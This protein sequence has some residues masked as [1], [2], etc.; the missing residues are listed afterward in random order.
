M[1]KSILL[2]LFTSLILVPVVASNYVFAKELPVIDFFY[3]ETCPHCI[4]EQAFFDEL[5]ELYPDLEVNRYSVS[6]EAN[7]DPMRERL[8]EVDAEKYF[9]SV[10]LTFVGDEF[11]LGFDDENGIGRDIVE[12]IDRQLSGEETRE[13]G[14]GLSVPFIGEVDVSQYSLPS[15]AVVLG[16]LDGFNVCSL[17]A[18]VL[19]LGMALM[20]QSRKKIALYGGIFIFTTAII[21]GSLIFLW[22]SLFSA[23]AKY[24]GL[25]QISIGLLGFVGG[26]YFLREYVKMRKYG[27]TCNSNG[28]PIIGKLSERMQKVFEGGSSAVS[29]GLAILL[30][31]AA[32]TIVEFPCS[33]AV[34]VFFAGVLADASLV[35]TTYWLYISLFVLFYMLDEL[36]I[37][38]VAVYR[39]NI[40]LTS[41]RFVKSVTLLEGLILAG[42]GIFYLARTLL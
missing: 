23:L 30:F 18:L 37:F 17:G 14:G 16:I 21:Y 40:W 27:V 42:I 5:E 32:I 7:L 28:M 41:P 20:L 11:F 38:G 31:A 12:S 6:E 10:P 2:T 33:A 26:I 9:G 29:L 36:I 39:M 19:I 3:S 1:R 34:P 13:D 24:V 15:L 35:P 25:I 22:F 4:R 8:R